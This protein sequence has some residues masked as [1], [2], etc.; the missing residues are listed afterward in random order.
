[1]ET[2]RGRSSRKRWMDLLEYDLRS[3][4]IKNWREVFQDGGM[5]VEEA[6]KIFPNYV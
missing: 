1:M 4:G 3:L 5:A 6:K 2:Y